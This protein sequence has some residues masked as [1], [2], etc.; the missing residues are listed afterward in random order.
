MKLLQ[1]DK[2]LLYTVNQT[3][4]LTQSDESDPS[5]IITQGPTIP[6]PNNV[7][8]GVTLGCNSEYPD[9]PHEGGTGRWSGSYDDVRYYDR[10]LSSQ[11]IE[12]IYHMSKRMDVKMTQKTAGGIGNTSISYS[13]ANGNSLFYTQSQFTGGS[14]SG[15]TADFNVEYAEMVDLKPIRPSG[16]L[17]NYEGH[18]G[19]EPGDRPIIPGGESRNYEG[20]I[21]EADE[22]R[23]ITPGGDTRT[24]EGTVGR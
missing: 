22:T 17:R 2:Y 3:L 21:G 20:L 15:S 24:Y 19:E 16:E 10:I 18:I 14:D 6:S 1:K 5:S 23:P 7:Y 11:E 8:R 4:E 9:T 12:K 13:L